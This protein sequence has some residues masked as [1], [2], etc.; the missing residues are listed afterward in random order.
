LQRKIFPHPERR[1]GAQ[2]GGA[3]RNL[4]AALPM[5]DNI[6]FKGETL[7]WI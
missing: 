4:A 6:P 7:R 3:I 2:D 1:R 5:R